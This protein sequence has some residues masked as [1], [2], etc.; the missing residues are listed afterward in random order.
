MRGHFEKLGSQLSSSVDS[1]NKT[2]ASYETRVLVSA[3]RFKEL[4]SIDGNDEME[5]LEP[6]EKTTR[7]LSIEAPKE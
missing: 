6:I 2:M 1:Y 7:A 3:R 5:L 4:K